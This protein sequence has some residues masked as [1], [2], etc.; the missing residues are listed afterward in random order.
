[1]PSVVRN[2]FLRTTALRALS[3]EGILDIG[4]A[5]RAKLEDLGG[6]GPIFRR[7]VH[8]TGRGINLDAPASFK[9]EFFSR[10]S[11]K[12]SRGVIHSSQQHRATAPGERRS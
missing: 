7:A 3:Q 6:T 4:G 8:V 2:D 11:G 1:M 10:V 5:Y 9:T 12:M